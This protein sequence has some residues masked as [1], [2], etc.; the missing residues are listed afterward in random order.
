MEM[1]LKIQYI[2]G[3]GLGLSLVAKIVKSYNGKIWVED[4]IRGDYTQGSNFVIILP[5]LI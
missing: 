4:R 1:E 2:S 5:E 3:M